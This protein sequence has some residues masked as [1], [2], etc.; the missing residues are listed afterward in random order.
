MIGSTKKASGEID[1]LLGQDDSVV[2]EKEMGDHGVGECVFVKEGDD[3]DESV[4]GDLG[5]E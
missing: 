1:L 4:F 5:V 3:A 2:A